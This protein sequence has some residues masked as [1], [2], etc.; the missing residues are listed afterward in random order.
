MTE[1]R[2]SPPI[3]T[4]G[5][6]ERTAG[7]STI[8][9]T[10]SA[11]RQL[12]T[13]YQASLA[14]GRASSEAEVV[15][16]LGKHLS[17][18]E[19]D[20]GMVVLFRN[21][22][23]PDG[24][25]CNQWDRSPRPARREP[26]IPSSIF[27]SETEVLNQVPTSLQIRSELRRYLK[28]GTESA[29]TI[30]MHGQD[31]MLGVLV[32][33]SRQPLDFDHGYLITY[34]ALASQAAVVLENQ[35]LTA[36][37]RERSLQMDH[38]LAISRSSA[39]IIDMR[40]TFA[41]IT[42]RVADAFG[43]QR[44][45][46]ALVDTET[47]TVHGHSPAFGV[48]DAVAHSVRYPLL[49]EEEASWSLGDGVPAVTHIGMLD[50]TPPAVQELMEAL[51][52]TSLLA[53]PMV[54]EE[55]TLGIILVANR[56][57][58]FG[59]NEIQLGTVFA[60]QAAIVIRSAQ[61]YR[62]QERHLADME[63]LNKITAA[64][65]Q[66]L[67]LSEILDQTLI[68]LTKSLDADMGLVS[69]WDRQRKHLSMVAH[70]KMPRT[71][72]DGILARGLNSSLC[73]LTSEMGE[74]YRVGSIKAVA[75][76]GTKALTDN[77][78]RSYLGAPV[79]AGDQ[80][81][82]TFSVFSRR[83][84]WFTARQADLAAAVAQQVGV[85]VRNAL[86]YQET[87]E[88]ALQVQTAAEVSHAAAVELEPTALL[89]TAVDLIQH[90]FG[91][92][93]VTIF[94][95][96]HNRRWAEAWAATGEVGKKMVAMPYRLQ[97]GGSSIVGQVT[98]TGQSHLVE[99]VQAESDS[100]T[101]ELLPGTRSA[102]ALPL[103]A[104]G[105]VMG[106]LDLRSNS[107][108]AFTDE[109]LVILQTMADQIAVA[110][111]NARLIEEL[112]D[113]A[114]A[115]QSQAGQFATLLQ[116]YQEVQTTS[117]LSDQIQ[118]I[119]EGVVKAKLFR[120]AVLSVFDEAWQTVRQYSGYAGLTAE[121][122][123]FL[124]TSPAFT[125]EERKLHFQEGF[126][127]SNSYFIPAGENP[128]RDRAV[129]S[130]I[131]VGDFHDWDPEDMLSVPL[132]IGDRIV[133]TLNVD[134]PFDGRRP[135]EQSLIPLELFAGLAARTIENSRL[136]A[137]LQHLYRAASLFAAAGSR[138]DMCQL[139]VEQAQQVADAD[140]A[141]LLLVDPQT[142]RIVEQAEAGER[143]GDLD[144]HS[145][146]ELLQGPGK[147]A[148]ETG[149]PVIIQGAAEAGEMAEH[150]EQE[151]V[152]SLLALPLSVGEQLSGQV[153]LFNAAQRR[154]FTQGDVDQLQAVTAQASIA[155]TNM[156]LLTLAQRRALQLQTAAEI[157]RAATSVLDVGR[158]YTDTIELIRQRFDLYYVG[159]FVVDEAGK[160]AVLRAGTGA[161]GQKQVDVGHRLE[162]GGDS[163]IGQSIAQGSARIALDVG[164]EAVRFANPHLPDTR[165]EIALPLIAQDTVIGAVT[166]QSSKE[167]AFAREDVA[168]LQTIADQ[169]ANAIANARLMEQLQASISEARETQ[170]LQTHEQW[171][172]Q[173]TS[174]A[175]EGR[176][177]YEY[178]L[179]DLRPMD[180][181]AEKVDGLAKLEA[182]LQ[183]RGEVIGTLGVEA[184]A[185]DHHWSED[186][187]ALI[188]AVA[189]QVAL[190]MDTAYY[191]EQSERR[192]GL[193][194][195][196]AEIGQ[197]IASVLSSADLTRRAAELVGQVFGFYHTAILALN[198]E[199]DQLILQEATGHAGDI[200]KES[201]Y[202]LPVNPFSTPGLAVQFKEPVVAD[203]LDQEQWSRNPLLPDSR[204][205][206]AVPLVAG[207]DLLGILDV[208]SDKPA[209]FD[210]VDKAVMQ[211][212]AD[213]I[214]ASLQNARLFAETRE[215][216]AEQQMLFNVTTAAVT[217]QDLDEMLQTVADTIYENMGGTDLVIAMLDQDEGLL[218]E[219]ASAGAGTERETPIELPL[220]EG[221]IGWV[222]MTGEPIII[223]DVAR[224][225]RYLQMTP[226][227]QSELAVPI[228][229][230]QTVV[231]VIN[232]E[233]DIANAF[234]E[235]DLRLMQTLSGTLGAIIKSFNLVRDLQE[236]LRQLQE[237]DRLKS[238]FLANMSHEL[239]TPLNSIIGFSRV[240]LKGIDGPLTSLQEQDLTSIYNSGQH[241]LG[242][243]N[244]VLDLSKIEAGKMELAPEQVNIGEI[245]EVVMSSL[246]GLTK[247]TSVELI[248]EMPS[249]LPPVWADPFR[250]RQVL[251]NLV[252]NASKFTEEGSITVRAAFDPQAVFVQVIDTGIGIS[253]A[254]M[255][256]LFKSFSQVDSSSTRRVQ[257]TGLG[258]AISA[259]LMRMQ[260]GRIWV[261][262][263]QGK[264]SV[265]SIAIPRVNADADGPIQIL[266]D[267]QATEIEPMEVPETAPADN[268]I[269]S[270][271]DEQGVIDLYNRYL[272]DSG[273]DVVG[274]TDAEEGVELAIAMSDQLAAITVD[275]LMPKM[276]GWEIIRRLR[277]NP[278]TSEIPIIVC[279]IRRDEEQAKAFD[280]AHYLVKPVLQEDLLE[281]LT[282]CCT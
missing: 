186:D 262:S 234:D 138:R 188:S 269:L 174:R 89:Q 214:S 152:G 178:D 36:A 71:L 155:L 30:P 140:W 10:Q 29:A 134:D 60:G 249:K 277:R 257:G 9:P 201:N 171:T 70:H 196:A 233:S 131:S 14:L 130:H 181:A 22:E 65:S 144:V 38:L 103:M 169:L 119:T 215:R 164:L 18:G 224:S 105:L 77:E 133:G 118:M 270:I 259:N 197:S 4:A 261:D 274:A 96:D 163:M 135:D 53:I 19:F 217:T 236:V 153:R 81:L 68:Q 93:H 248:R 85:A 235:D 182:P 66:S 55:E 139:V 179:M 220:G 75:E 272:S 150:W 50:E 28:S 102:M 92:Y 143:I 107:T 228:T 222:A 57:G 216:A 151:G 94:V 33:E 210:E 166:V 44:C 136:F 40:Q 125:R 243:I 183:L 109:D 211:T 208:H 278:T 227:T 86:R 199:G 264:G 229:V 123:R 194:A 172:R 24:E 42:S 45:V 239:R 17:Y 61:L 91:Y 8:D 69:M 3:V 167:A 46:L 113:S 127:I 35:R 252:S 265:F 120:R 258:L 200:M 122:I 280:I 238:E 16:A 90:R 237:V 37:E 84:D 32:L 132:W 6:G 246:V 5:A 193:M 162:V 187:V 209:A 170:R 74:V 34:E 191:S 12:T 156:Q 11:L 207:G 154:Q 124:Q 253:E 112:E 116:V 82:G 198:K 275:I 110:L 190:A 79:K 206:M 244:A 276:D 173:A 256:K 223:G 59:Q 72:R 225:T 137:N 108:A 26:W 213:Q 129:S 189:E 13:L 111:Q 54:L 251:L 161:A 268:L 99:D 212:V 104:R 245:I 266:I 97:V 165:S 56:Q 241:L 203:D 78:L 267:E 126:R 281:A 7:R 282:S 185:P 247:D 226:S 128:L 260:G 231:G 20:R 95:L 192:A 83:R 64:T 184:D 146:A 49:P 177:G 254:D 205:E 271:D 142:Q 80:V 273:F 147:D 141:N 23:E 219:S 48:T 242:L 279:S 115:A 21:T 250:L 39:S 121:E 159:I 195:S 180:A 221:L 31:G 230:D 204:S 25:I 101:A 15:E 157:S 106:A 114:G 240:I 98:E 52:A 67:D 27:S 255:A 47:G 51:S 263:K 168:I 2:T 76:V 117:E 232:I 202:A 73:S 88:R 176:A 218:R 58:G 149:Q 87:E 1:T 175:A 41:E 62:A 63:F 158:L 160:W 43:A 100:L 145:Y 148:M